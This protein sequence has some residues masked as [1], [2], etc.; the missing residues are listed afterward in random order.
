MPLGHLYVFSGENLGLLSIFFCWVVFFPPK[1]QLLASLIFSAVLSLFHLFLLIFMFS[2]LLSTLG[3]VCS[4]SSNC[5]RCKAR[6]RKEPHFK[7]LR[8]HPSI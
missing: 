3:F 5:L 4:Y 2:F 1:N 6:L 8:M 7:Y